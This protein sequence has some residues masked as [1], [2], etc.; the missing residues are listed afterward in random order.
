MAAGAN[1]NPPVAAAR[2]T[3]PSHN[4]AVLDK[5]VKVGVDARDSF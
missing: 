2:R 1:F 3:F 5:F 4:E